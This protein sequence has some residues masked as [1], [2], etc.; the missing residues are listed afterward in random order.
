MTNH[1]VAIKFDMTIKK[2]KVKKSN[3]H[4]AIKFW[5]LTRLDKHYLEPEVLA[6]L[7]INDRNNRV[8]K[9]KLEDQFTYPFSKKNLLFYV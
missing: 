5:N 9:K 7:Q 1:L 6:L 2:G 3:L 4:N 8:R